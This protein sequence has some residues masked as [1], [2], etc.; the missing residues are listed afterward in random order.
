MDF[1]KTYRQTSEQL[2]LKYLDAIIKHNE[3]LKTEFLAF[4]TK[5]E[6][7]IQ[8]ASYDSFFARVKEIQTIYKGNFE[9]VDTENPDWESYQQP[10][11]GYIEEW[12]AYQMASEQEFEGY[13]GLFIEEAINQ[14]IAQKP[15]EM[16][17]ML[18]GLF[19]AA[20]HANIIDEVGSFED[21]N[22][23][24]LSEH[25]NTTLAVAEKLRHSALASNIINSSFELFFRYCSEE[26]TENLHYVQNFEAVL[27]ALAEK[28]E[29]PGEIYE[30]MVQAAVDQSVLPELTLLLHKATGNNEAWLK[31]AR[32]MYQGSDAV[33]KELLHYYYGNDMPSFVET[34]NTLLVTNANS[35]A[36]F[37]IAYVDPQMDEHLFVQVFSALVISEKKIEYYKKL[38]PYLDNGTRD[39]II[40]NVRW[41]RVFL[42]KLFAEDGC[43][44]EIKAVVEKE[45][46]RWFF[47]E[48]IAPILAVY[49]DFCFAKIKS[50]VESSLATE[51]G[52]STYER[53][54]TWLALAKQIPGHEAD[55]IHLIKTTY[56][57]KPNLP[58]LRDEMRKAGL[59]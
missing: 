4:V 42:V 47:A 34:A 11:S 57:H 37:L 26:F 30:F 28:T 20:L 5:Q 35:W 14:L 29:N 50:M 16:L 43:H 56:A 38:K 22:E 10:H 13:F 24:L 18:V 39:H 33:A 1:D 9:S 44:A 15:D 54:A 7:A 12:E 58:A 55:V 51:R 48:L 45:K 23:F 21:V 17:A 36:A 3:K 8:S 2:K 32:Q 41:D 52:R 25:R 19:E 27:L 31:A 40:S 59:V 46:D 53:I 6:A 49:P